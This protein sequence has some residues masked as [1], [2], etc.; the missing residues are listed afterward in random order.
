MFLLGSSYLKK[1][2]YIKVLLVIM[3]ILFAII[4]FSIVL[5]PIVFLDCFEG[6]SLIPKE[7]LPNFALTN[8]LSFV[9]NILWPFV[10]ILFWWVMAPW[11]WVLTVVR[12]SEKE[13]HSGI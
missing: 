3:G 4:I 6:L 11:L 12:L 5:T 1:L 7:N 10:K 8:F 9:T 13:V 2:V